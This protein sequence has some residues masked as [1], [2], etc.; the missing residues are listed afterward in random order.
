MFECSIC[1]LLSLN[2]ISCPACGSQNLID[3]SSSDS[4]AEDLPTVIPGLDEAAESWHE[5]EGS[6]DVEDGSKHAI[7]ENNSQQIVGM[8]LDNIMA[9]AM[10][11]AV[12]VAHKKRALDVK[13]AVEFLKIKEELAVSIIEIVEVNNAGFA[14]PSQSLYVE[15]YP[16]EKSEIFNPKKTK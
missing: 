3:L 2:A 1:G 4:T 13:K 11:D 7:A 12:L 10:P 16:N 5:I 14:F 6:H 8:G 15:S 9:I